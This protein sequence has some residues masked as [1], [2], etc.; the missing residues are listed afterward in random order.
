MDNYK[1]LC[2]MKRLSIIAVILPVAVLAGC[3]SAFKSTSFSDD[4]YEIHNRTAIA[5]RKKAQAELAKAQAEAR[6][7]EWEAKLAEAKANAIQNG[8]YYSDDDAYINPYDAVLADTYESAYAR[9]LYGF[10]S[11]TYRMPSSYFALRY[12]D[13]FHY[14]SAYDPAFYN[15]MVSGDQV[16]VEPKY[17]TSMFGTWGASVAYPSYGWYC[18][19]ASPYNYAWWGYPRYSWYD[20]Y[21]WNWAYNWGW[22][23]GYYNP[24]WGWGFSW[25][26]PYWPHYHHHPPYHRPPH[27]GRPG[28]IVH[29]PSTGHSFGSGSYRYSVNSGYNRN[30]NGTIRR[31]TGGTTTG[32]GVYRG[33]GNSR[34]YNN[35]NSSGQYRSNTRSPFGGERNN[36]SQSFNRG[37]SNRGSIGYSGGGNF[38]GSSH[39]GGQ[40]RR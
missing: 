5:E 13:A 12:S 40:H 28:N 32:S 4:L 34:S 35:S 31:N 18:G 30:S 17:I 33:S 10:Q 37:S 8:T 11:P 14:A 25:G 7:A 22:G 21:N 39:G 26:Y 2:T 20:W 38:S 24:W 1:T 9:R 3:S 19:W 27:Y 29:R 23:F 6:Q 15:V 36:S 16:W